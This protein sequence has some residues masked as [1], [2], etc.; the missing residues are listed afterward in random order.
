MIMLASM[1]AGYKDD[2]LCDLAETYHI[3]D[4]KALPAEYLATLCCGLSS[5]SR[6]MMKLAGQQNVS[7]ELLLADIADSLRAIVYAFSDGSHEPEKWRTLIFQDAEEPDRK[8]KE[9]HQVKAYASIEG[10]QN[11]WKRITG[12]ERG[13][14]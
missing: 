1:L 4:Y 12:G 8:N 7:K 11:E 3:Y 5:D 2:L 10:F 9:N 6:I 14:R 13:G